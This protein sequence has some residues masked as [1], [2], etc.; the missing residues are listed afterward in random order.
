M[1]RTSCIKT[2]FDGSQPCDVPN[3]LWRQDTEPHNAPIT[4]TLKGHVNG[5][6]VSGERDDPLWRPLIRK[7]QKKLH[8]VIAF[9]FLFAQISRSHNVEHYFLVL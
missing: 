9:H 8:I 1:K 6:E 5:E 7:S 4:Q 2:I 3:I